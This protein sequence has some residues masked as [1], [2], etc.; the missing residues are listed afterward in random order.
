MYMYVYIYIYIHTY[1]L[2]RV[3]IADVGQRHVRADL[4]DALQGYCLTY[5]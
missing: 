5:C 3:P 4:G 2:A 1:L